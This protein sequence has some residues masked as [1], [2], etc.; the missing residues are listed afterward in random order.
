MGPAMI[1]TEDTFKRNPKTL[2]LREIVA[3]SGHTNGEAMTSTDAFSEAEACY[4]FWHF[5]LTLRD[6]TLLS[7]STTLVHNN[8]LC[9]LDLIPDVIYLSSTGYTHTTHIP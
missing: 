6:R 1:A 9:H 7:F 4:L 3:K 8:Q 5:L 2:P